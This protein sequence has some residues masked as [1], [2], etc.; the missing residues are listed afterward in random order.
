MKTVRLVPLAA[1]VLAAQGLVWGQTITYTGTVPTTFS[2]LDTSNNPVALTDNSVFANAIGSGTVRE[3]TQQIRLRSNATYKLSAQVTSHTS[4]ADGTGATAGNT[5]EAITLGDIG[6]GISNIDASG[7]SVV[8]GGGSPSRTDTTATGFTYATPTPS[9][10]RIAWTTDTLHSILA[11]STQMLSG[12]RISASGDNGSDD[13]F[14]TVSLK[15][16]Y[17]PQY[18]TPTDV[19]GGTFTVVVTLTVAASGS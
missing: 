9:D 5:A 14:L 13:N 8:N 18:F 10:G 7:A 3:S 1:V 15:A 12:D 19:S 16:G 6:F 2:I 11:S 17:L 4:I